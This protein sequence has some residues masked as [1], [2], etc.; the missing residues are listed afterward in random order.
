MGLAL[1]YAPLAAFLIL[2]LGYAYLPQPNTLD[3]IQHL[4]YGLSLTDQARMWPDWSQLWLYTADGMTE[5]TMRNRIQHPPVWY[6]WVGS[7]ADLLR[8]L[9]RVDLFVLRLP[10]LALVIFG[11][12]AVGNAFAALGRDMATA[13]ALAMLYLVAVP[14]L[15]PVSVTIG[16][17]ALAI[18]A[19]LYAVAAAVSLFDSDRPG[20]KPLVALLG[21]VAIAGLAKA[22][23]ALLV[24]GFAAV[25]LTGLLRR[26]G[27]ELLKS[28][29]ALLGCVFIAVCW[30][31]YLM[32][33]WQTGSPVPATP[34]TE[35]ELAR[36]LATGE[37]HPPEAWTV[38]AML[39]EHTQRMM[40][41]WLLD[42]RTG[43]GLLLT[44][45]LLLI[46][47]AAGVW[48]SMYRLRHGTGD[49]WDRTV[50]A[51]ALAAL[52]FEAFYLV[53]TY[54]TLTA[55]GG[56]ASGQP[57]Y[58]FPLLAIF[59]AALVRFAGA[60]PSGLARYLVIGAIAAATLAG[61]AFSV[62]R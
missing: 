7:L 54:G 15:A 38:S 48:V 13:P 34:G 49:G 42:S 56:Y 29:D 16:N 39:A 19:G 40:R 17:D 33:T 50:V 3:E 26:H 58:F 44:L 18:A 60:L 57:R 6:W 24:G 47:A 14:L 51:G 52:V 41:F 12:V 28:R 45:P 10:G 11:L 59:A 9:D 22:T 62:M 32:L 25:V 35:A 1:R 2:A 55:H 30:S 37:A 43:G 53:W 27:P 5:T 8:P 46:A 31:P 20:G 4:S 36:L 23:A 61:G 21:S